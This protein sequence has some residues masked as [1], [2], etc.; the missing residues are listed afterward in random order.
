V[1]LV[2]GQNAND[3]ILSFSTGFGDAA[4]IVSVLLLARVLG[5]VIGLAT[6]SATV[7]MISRPQSRGTKR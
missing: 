4:A 6:G 2:A 5:V 3:A 7:A 1:R